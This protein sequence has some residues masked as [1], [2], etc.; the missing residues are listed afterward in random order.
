MCLK[1]IVIF[2]PNFSKGGIER[3][4]LLLSN[5]FNKKRVKLKFISF[6]KIDNKKFNF[7]KDI[8]FIYKKNK[9]FY[10]NNFYC[11]YN[12]TKV[13]LRSNRKNTIVFS[14]Q[15]NILSIIVSKILGF[16]IVV[17]NAAPI[18]YFK[19]QRNV[20]NELKLFLK[21]KIYSY[22]DLIISNSKSSARKIKDKLNK[23][24]KIISI[25]NPIFNTVNKKYKIKKKNTILYVGR[26]SKEKGIFELIEGFE[27]FQKKYPKFNLDIVG[28]G[29][30]KKELIKF[31]KKKKISSKVNLI[32]WNNNLNHYYKQSKILILPSLYEGFGN[33]L[34]EALNYRLPCIATNNDGPKEILNFGK[35]GLLMK[36]NKPITIYKSLQKMIENYNSYQLKSI[37]GYK[38]NQKYHINI[39]G[40]KYYNSIKNVLET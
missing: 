3:V 15:N 40:S 18:D 11:T 8:D 23:K 6:K 36:N 39:V 1:N 22:S 19:N 30:Q 2:F 21:I 16:K 14:L 26:L 32:D 24:N 35:F 4:S 25:P 29:N 33:V 10:F 17:R 13:L 12:L 5:F 37:Q 34:I 38:N 28:D 20:I 7:S 27:I 9:Y 31:I